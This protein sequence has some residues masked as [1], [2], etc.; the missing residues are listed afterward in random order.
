MSKILDIGLGYQLCVFP[1]AIDIVKLLHKVVVT[2]YIL[3][4]NE[5]HFLYIFANIEYFKISHFCY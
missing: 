5:Y 1:F 2:V 4:G 3:S